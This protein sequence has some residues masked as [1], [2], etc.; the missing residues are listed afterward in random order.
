MCVQSTGLF[1]DVYN[2][3]KSKIKMTSNYI[4]L[5]KS[6]ASGRIRLSNDGAGMIQQ[7]IE[8]LNNYNNKNPFQHICREI[9]FLG[10]FIYCYVDKGRGILNTKMKLI[11]FTS[12]GDNP[13]YCSEGELHLDG[14]DGT[15]FTLCGLSLD[16]DPD[17]VGEYKV[18]NASKVTCPRCMAIIKKCRGVKI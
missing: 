1:T 3:L 9:L 7:I 12:L 2:K 4:I 10:R 6:G 17:S 14:P 18:V 11:Q 15:D 5:F 16:G 13:E 8:T